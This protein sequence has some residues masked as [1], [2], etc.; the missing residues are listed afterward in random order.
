MAD[1]DLEDLVDPVLGQRT[2]TSIR[3]RA[4]RVVR[5]TLFSEFAD[6][7]RSNVFGWPVIRP[8]FLVSDLIVMTDHHTVVGRQM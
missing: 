6:P 7:G 8:V 1:R 3:T 4:E 5:L 2:A